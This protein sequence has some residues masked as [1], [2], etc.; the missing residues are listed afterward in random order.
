MWE[1][2]QRLKANDA[3]E[4]DPDISGFDFSPCGQN[5]YVGTE[6]SIEV[7]K[8]NTGLRTSFPCKKF[9]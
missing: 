5:L 8:I 2:C 9:A 3:L 7:F 6:S 1:Q 4:Y